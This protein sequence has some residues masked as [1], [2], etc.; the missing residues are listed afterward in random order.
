MRAR[1]LFALASLHTTAH[2]YRTLFKIHLF[3]CGVY[4]KNNTVF[5]CMI[6]S[7]VLS[8]KLAEEILSQDCY[9]S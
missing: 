8:L 9:S 1:T 3:L 4:T 6:C 2:D 7:L 5:V